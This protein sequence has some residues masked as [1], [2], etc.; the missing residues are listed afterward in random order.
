M[1]GIHEK[2]HAVWAWLEEFQAT[3][4]DRSSSFLFRVFV[5]NLYLLKCANLLTIW[6]HYF[7][8][9]NV[10]NPHSARYLVVD[11]TIPYATQPWYNI[12]YAIVFVAYENDCKRHWFCLSCSCKQNL[13]CD[14]FARIYSD[15]RV[16]LFNRGAYFRWGPL[17][18]SCY[19]Q[20]RG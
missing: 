19:F 6:R 4:F 17:L 18:S 7:A 1:Q 13:K 9:I 14:V 8:I 10:K 3:A 16:G 20:H 15:M 11:M 12:T 2:S 5:L